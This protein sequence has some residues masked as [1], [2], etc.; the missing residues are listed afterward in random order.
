MKIFNDDEVYSINEAKEILKI[1]ENTLKNYIYEGR[2][3][4]FKVADKTIRIKGSELNKLLMP[5][6]QSNEKEIPEQY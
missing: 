5:I 1:S 3:A 2:L 6:G 4:A